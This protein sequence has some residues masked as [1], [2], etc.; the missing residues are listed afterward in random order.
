MA[1]KLVVQ[2]VLAQIQVLWP[3]TQLEK[4]V[5]ENTDEAY[6]QVVDQAEDRLDAIADQIAN[7]LDL[8]RDHPKDGNQHPPRPP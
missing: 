8:G 3:T 5:K 2:S 7:Q 1:S 4:L 6:H